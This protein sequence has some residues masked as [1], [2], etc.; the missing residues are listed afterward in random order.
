[1]G[2]Q[3]FVAVFQLLI[4]FN[5]AISDTGGGVKGLFMEWHWV[6]LGFKTVSSPKSIMAIRRNENVDLHLQWRLIQPLV[7]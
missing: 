7:K 5:Y 6:R 3:L 4:E 2:P 1:M